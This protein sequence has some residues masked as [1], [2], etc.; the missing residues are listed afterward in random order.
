MIKLKTEYKIEY[1]DSH[2]YLL[3]PM[4]GLPVVAE[5]ALR[6]L[7]VEGIKKEDMEK[8]VDWLN[9]AILSTTKAAVAARANQMQEQE[10]VGLEIA[11]AMPGLKGE[12]K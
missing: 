3:N 10:S 11:S 5:T 6:D 2:L 9:L 8:L 12:E 7:G 1:L 4:I